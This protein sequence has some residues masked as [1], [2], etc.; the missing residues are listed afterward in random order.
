[1]EK[2]M[3]TAGKQRSPAI[4]PPCSTQWSGEAEESKK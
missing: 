2:R 4:T 3:G 1:M